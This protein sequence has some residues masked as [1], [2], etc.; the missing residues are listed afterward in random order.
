MRVTA[1]S[2]IF[3]FVSLNVSLYLIAETQVLPF[4]LQPFEQPTDITNR[5]VGSLTVLTV[6]ALVAFLVGNAL[7]GIAGLMLFILNLF[8]PVFRWIF[9]G[10]PEF[11]TILA[12][13]TEN[14]ALVLT[15]ITATNSLM[16]V[17]WLWFFMGFLSQ[18]VMER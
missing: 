11:L 14:P 6:G 4:Y 17:V 2:I 13:T 10:L 7:I 12:N 8:L 16:A 18:R 1:Y 3:F 9:F 15:V 5:L